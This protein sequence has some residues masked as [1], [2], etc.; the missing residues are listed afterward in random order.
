MAGCLI[1]RFPPPSQKESTPPAES[2]RRRTD[3]VLEQGQEYQIITALQAKS[4]RAL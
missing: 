1:K 3:G 4:L 2:M